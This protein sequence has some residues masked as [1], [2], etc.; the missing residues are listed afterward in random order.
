MPEQTWREKFSEGHEEETADF[1]RKIAVIVEE[2]KSADNRGHLLYLEG[3]DFKSNELDRDDMRIWQAVEDGSITT[4]RFAAYR[5]RLQQIDSPTKS[6]FLSIIASRAT[7]VIVRR[8]L[9]EG[10]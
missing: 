1:R 2:M 9:A 4:E 7:V 8:Q 3:A 6:T 5:R 10:K